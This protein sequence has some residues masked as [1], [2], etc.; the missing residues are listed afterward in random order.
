M[1]KYDSTHGLF[2]G[3]IKVVD[4]ST[5]EINGKQIKVVSKRYI[6]MNFNCTV[7]NNPKFQCSNNCNRVDLICFHLRHNNH[8]SKLC[9]R[10]S[11]SRRC[12][13]SWVCNNSQI[14]Y[15]VK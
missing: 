9:H 5:I 6:A 3:S 7:P 2:K 13:N 14:H 15:N 12:N 11:H 1:F 8:N 10:F 4:D